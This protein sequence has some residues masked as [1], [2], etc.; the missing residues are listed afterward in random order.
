[1]TGVAAIACAAAEP[2]A[3]STKNGSSSAARERTSAG[4]C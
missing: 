2:K 4:R 1:M 3:I